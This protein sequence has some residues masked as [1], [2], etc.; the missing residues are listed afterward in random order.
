MPILHETRLEG[1]PSELLSAP[2]SS[3]GTASFRLS[4]CLPQH[5]RTPAHPAVGRRASTASV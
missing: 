2:F 1:V 5:V 4:F 3:A